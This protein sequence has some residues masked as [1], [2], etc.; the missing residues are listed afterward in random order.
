MIGSFLTIATARCALPSGRLLTICCCKAWER[1]RTPAPGR[2]MPSHWS[3]PKLNIVTQ[4][5]CTGTQILH[6]VGCAEVPR[7]ATAHP[8][9]TQKAT[10]DYRE[11]KEIVS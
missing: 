9:A 11:F 6:A 5:S 2:Q 1:R 3:Y 8:Q 10:G 4:S 7:Y